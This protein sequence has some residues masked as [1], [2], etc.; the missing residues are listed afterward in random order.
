MA[1]ANIYK[2]LQKEKKLLLS[3]IKRIGLHFQEVL[4]RNKEFCRLRDIKLD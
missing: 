1:S 4:Q 2:F 3:T